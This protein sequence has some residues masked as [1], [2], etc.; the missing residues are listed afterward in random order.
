MSKVSMRESISNRVGI[1]YDVEDTEISLVLNT[2]VNSCMQDAIVCGQAT[3]AGEDING[4]VAI[5]VEEDLL[6]M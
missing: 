1:P 5:C 4:V 6:A 2:E 3:K